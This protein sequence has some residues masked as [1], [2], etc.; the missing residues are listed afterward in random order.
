MTSILHHSVPGNASFVCDK[1]ILCPSYFSV[2]LL[3]MLILLLLV[4]G[5]NGLFSFVIKVYSF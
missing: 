1:M 2:N 4:I 3:N 5:T